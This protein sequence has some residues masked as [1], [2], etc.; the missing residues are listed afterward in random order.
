MLRHTTIFPDNPAPPCCSPAPP[1]QPAGDPE[2]L[3]TQCGLVSRRFQ[4]LHLCLPVLHQLVAGDTWR[5]LCTEM[6][7]TGVNTC[8][9]DILNHQYHSNAVTV[10]QPLSISY[11]QSLSIDHCH[12]IPVNWS[13]SSIVVTQ[14]LSLDW[15]LLIIFTRSMSINHC[16]SIT[17]NQL[18]SLICHKSTAVHYSLTNISF[19]IMTIVKWLLRSQPA[20]WQPECF[21]LAQF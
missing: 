20:D 1:H 4:P 2:G 21:C 5:H 9:A 7:G 6:I 14:T 16:D 11:C 17:V 8:Q 19:Q 10:S 18:L 3:V 13:L 12:S 15:C